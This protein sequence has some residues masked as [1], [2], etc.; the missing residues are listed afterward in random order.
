VT[1]AAVALLCAG[2]LAAGCGGD[3][4]SDKAD[5]PRHALPDLIDA[6][7]AGTQSSVDDPA[8]DVRRHDLPGPRRA[9]DRRP[10]PAT[11]L[12]AAAV[13]VTSEHVC[14]AARSAGGS[15]ATLG[16]FA[17][18]AGSPQA[19]FALSTLGPDA[20]EALVVTGDKQREHV[21]IEFAREGAVVQ[22]AVERGAL[23]AAPLDGD[24]DWQV[25]TTE[26]VFDGNVPLTTFTDCTEPT[27]AGGGEA[28][29]VISCPVR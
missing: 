11:D 5:P 10:S 29:K 27:R 6:C 24:F 22:L 28:A 9:P 20:D 16:L 3:G 7:R 26:P 19:R 15:P 23:R 14:V 4:D 12:R 21:P 8:G 1:R 18:P 25:E 13:G 2:S 17:Q